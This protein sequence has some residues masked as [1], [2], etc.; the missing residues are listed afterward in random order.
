MLKPGAG[1]HRCSRKTGQAAIGPGGGCCSEACNPP[2]SSHP[3][4]SWR[5]KLFRR[6]LPSQ[7]HI[8]IKD[9]LVHNY[10]QLLKGC[11]AAQAS[12]PRSLVFR[13][14]Q[15]QQQQQHRDGQPNDMRV[16]KLWNP[17]SSSILIPFTSMST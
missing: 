16:N 15:Q 4:T 5:S 2:T 8:N 7:H 6:S 17:T 11:S 13:C 12:H 10:A 14:T 3:G 9:Q 1:G